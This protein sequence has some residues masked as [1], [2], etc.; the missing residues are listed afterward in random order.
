MKYKYILLIFLWLYFYGNVNAQTNNVFRLKAID[1]TAE[2]LC[3]NT[4]E[5]KS[6]NLD[7]IPTSNKIEQKIKN[8]QEGNRVFI[9]FLLSTE[10]K[11][12][13]LNGTQY[14]NSDKKPF[15][16]FVDGLIIE[17]LIV[18]SKEKRVGTTLFNTLKF[19]LNT[20]KEE[21]KQKA[22]LDS[23]ELLSSRNDSAID[24]IIQILSNEPKQ[25]QEKITKKGISNSYLFL[26]LITF[27]LILIMGFISFWVYKK[28]KEELSRKTHEIN[29]L[30]YNS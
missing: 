21:E 14:K 12:P 11:Y 3:K 18:N 19:N 29:E 30:K 2:Y 22:I 24:S 1:I 23:I 8:F 28:F 20:L 10:G 16:E 15:S 27:S 7:E 17:I 25:V 6:Y 4:N 26:L 5:G 9:N 13:A